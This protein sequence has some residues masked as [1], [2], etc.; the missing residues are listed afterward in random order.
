LPLCLL[1][2]GMQN[3]RIVDAVF[4]SVGARPNARV[5]TNSMM[6]IYCYLR[7]GYWSSVVPRSFVEWLAP[8]PGLHI[9]RL[10]EPTVTKAVGLVVA[11]RDPIPPLLTA[12]WEHIERETARER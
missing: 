7:S 5:E 10:I 2:R 12:F 6:S 4:E 3:R 8:P 9:A 1:D 11:D